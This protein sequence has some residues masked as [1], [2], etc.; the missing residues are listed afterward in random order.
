MLYNDLKLNELKIKLHSCLSLGYVN[1]VCNRNNISAKS[2][3]LA[4]SFINSIWALSTNLKLSVSKSSLCQ[5]RRLFKIWRY[6]NEEFYTFL[7]LKHPGAVTGGE[8]K[9]KRVR[10]KFGRRK[11]KN[12]EKRFAG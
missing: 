3:I 11:V 9:S 8:K 7:K 5:L 6:F 2:L 4:W 12:E 1:F 10:K